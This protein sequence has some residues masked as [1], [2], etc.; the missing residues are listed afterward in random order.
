MRDQKQMMPQSFLIEMRNNIK[1]HICIYIV[2]CKALITVFGT[3][4]VRN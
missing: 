3:L 2:M 1:T 4:R